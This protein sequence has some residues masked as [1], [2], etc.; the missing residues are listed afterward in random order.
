[1]MRLEGPEWS[2]IQGNL[3]C[4]GSLSGGCLTPNSRSMTWKVDLKHMRYGKYCQCRVAVQP[5]VL[6]LRNHDVV[7]SWRFWSD[8][9]VRQWKS[10]GKIGRL[11]SCCSCNLSDRGCKPLVDG[12]GQESWP[13]K[14]I[15]YFGFDSMMLSH[16]W[17]KICATNK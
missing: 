12:A 13:C 2:P 4:S 8:A 5:K 14:D 11:R 9:C 16:S 7:V 3:P 17:K 1:M 15:G 6:L 10:K